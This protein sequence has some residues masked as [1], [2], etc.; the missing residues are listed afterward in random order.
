MKHKVFYEKK[1]DLYGVYCPKDNSYYRYHR[2]PNYCPMCGKNLKLF[3]SID[4]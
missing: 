3:K 4:E 2:K 1:N